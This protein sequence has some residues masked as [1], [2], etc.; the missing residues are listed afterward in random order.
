MGISGYPL[1]TYNDYV[2]MMG[3][4]ALVNGE[5][6]ESY[7]I[8]K[9]QFDRWFNMGSLYAAR[10]GHSAII[11][12]NNIIVFGG[13]DKHDT[14]L[15]TILDDGLLTGKAIEPSGDNAPNNYKFYPAMFIVP[16]DYC[17]N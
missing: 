16:N 2:I 17:R 5:A 8:C 6:R 10:E 12:E 3:G 14:E 15:W 13:R 9:Y 4:T 7:T 1:V 11:H